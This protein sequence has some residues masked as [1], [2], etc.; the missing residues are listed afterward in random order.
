M[1]Y[2]TSI[3]KSEYLKQIFS[4]ASG[5][6]L[7]QLI[8]LGSYLIITRLFSPNELGE[9]KFLESAAFLLAI[10]A[11]LSYEHAIILPKKRKQA[12][13]ILKIACVLVFVTF[14][15]CIFFWGIWRIIGYP[16]ANNTHLLLIFY[17][18]ALISGINIFS[19]WF[20]SQKQFLKLSIARI[21][22]SFST[23]ILQ[24]VFG[25]FSI[26]SFG[27]MIGYLSGRLISLLYLVCKAGITLKDI[28]QHTISELKKIVRKYIDQPKYILPSKLIQQ[29]AVEIP[30]LLTPFL[31]DD[32]IL[33]MFALARRALATPTQFLGV[34]VGQVYYK[35]ISER[36]NEKKFIVPLLLKTWGGLTIISIIPFGLLLFIGESIFMLVFGADWQ[37]AGK[38]ASIMAPALFLY[39][40]IGPTERA[41]FLALNLQH[42]ALLFSIID[43]IGKST[44]MITG[45]FIGDFFMC[46]LLMT[47]AQATTTVLIA[48]TILNQSKKTDARLNEHH[49]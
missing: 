48:F 47:V 33:G 29:I 28:T 45:Y 20:I 46:I 32:Y 2:L 12:L 41:S 19:N 38:I 16:F 23:S 49:N 24:I 39:F 34:S 26:G 11:T 25:F 37:D 27:L 7:A 13:G 6:A 44:A 17:A 21:F 10:I 35:Q 40:I 30:F 14:L 1:K 9:F 18:M 15:G 8:T 4:L 31:F 3:S 5:T 36:V 43:L 22:Q 42:K